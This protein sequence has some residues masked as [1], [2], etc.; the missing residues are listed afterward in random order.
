MEEANEN[1]AFDVFE[2]KEL[3]LQELDKQINSE[4]RIFELKKSKN[5]N[6]DN[7]EENEV[8]EIRTAI[9]NNDELYLRQ[10]EVGT[11]T[12]GE[13]TGNNV[14]A[15]NIIIDKEYYN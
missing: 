3:K 2:T 4:K 1:I 7:S 8:D 9:E 5:I 14:S 10:F 11:M 15:G 13:A 6:I 12:I